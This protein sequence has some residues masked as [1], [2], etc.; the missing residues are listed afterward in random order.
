[1]LNN[2]VQQLLLNKLV[3]VSISVSN[4]LI[5][6]ISAETI[7]QSIRW[8]TQSLSPTIF[9]L[10]QRFKTFNKQKSQTLSSFW[11]LKYEDLNIFG[12]W[13]VGWT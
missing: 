11:L 10:Y 7:S 2:A 9:I 13:T 8:L 3:K 6:K 5:N 12:F 4:Y 1:M